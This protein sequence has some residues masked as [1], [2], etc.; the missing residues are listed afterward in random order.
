MINNLSK[1]NGIIIEVWIK[2]AEVKLTYIL[3]VY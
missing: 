3:M 2:M 1:C